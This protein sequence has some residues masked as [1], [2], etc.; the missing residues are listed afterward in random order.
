MVQLPELPRLLLKI[1]H[2]LFC[3]VF[4]PKLDWDITTLPG[5]AM[6]PKGTFAP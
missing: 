1:P 5:Q 4:V 2:I 3:I 6:L